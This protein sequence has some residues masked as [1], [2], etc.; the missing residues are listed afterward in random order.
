MKPQ[1]AIKPRRK[2]RTPILDVVGVAISALAVGVLGAL[3]AAHGDPAFAFRLNVLLQHVYSF[4]G[5]ALHHNARCTYWQAWSLSPP[6]EKLLADRAVLN[7][8]QV[9][10]RDGP[11]E[12]V[13]TPLGPFW[14]PVREFAVLA[15]TVA[16]QQRDVYES[17]ASGVQRGDV[18]LDCG[19]N[20]GVYTRH[21]LDRGAKLVVAIEPAPESLECLRRNLDKEIASGR[22]VV[23]PKGVWN[24]DDEL[25]LSISDHWASTA[26]SVVLDRGGKGPR[27]PLTTIDKV[28][29]E[30]KLPSV[31]FIKMDIEG[32]EMEA[33]EGAVE[34]VRRFRPRMAISVEH[35]PRDPDEIPKLVHRLW[36]DYRYE[37]GPCVNVSGSIQPDV[38][39]AE[40]A[41]P[42]AQA[43]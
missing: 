21:A 38:L 8:L 3:I 41:S 10:K 39:F 28:A 42:V 17:T 6:V 36:P 14:I 26:A 7:A 20:I 2:S 15:E 5:A 27:V 12:L 37:C 23:Y 30:L 18:V 16:E 13:R 31:D 4:P 22:V 34:T 24:K 35:R 19:A 29:A 32:A 25:Q 43:H 40:P 1:G 9:E 11:M 33:L